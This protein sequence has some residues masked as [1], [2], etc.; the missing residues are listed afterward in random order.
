VGKVVLLSLCMSNFLSFF[1]YPKTMLLNFKILKYNYIK[2]LIKLILNFFLEVLGSKNRDF[3][4]Y[5]FRE[6]S[7]Y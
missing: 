3:Y 1:F 7:V 2:I 5:L 6:L 4:F